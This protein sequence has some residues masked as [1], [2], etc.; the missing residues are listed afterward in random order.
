MQAY[1]DLMRKTM[2]EGADRSA[3]GTGSDTRSLFGAQLRI[4]LKD[5]FPLVTTRRLDFR[6]IVAELLWSIKGD[7]NIA[8]LH[9]YNVTKWDSWADE[10]GYVGPVYGE[11]WRRWECADSRKVDQLRNLIAQIKF[12]PYSRRL[13]LSS[14]NVAYVDQMWVPPSNMI[15]QFY[16]NNNDLGCILSQRTSDLYKRVPETLASYALLTHLMAK[17]CK[18]GVG[19]LIWTGGDVHLYHDDFAKANEQM[20]HT[21]R[22]LSQLKILRDVNFIDQYEVDDI[23]VEGYDPVE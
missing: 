7:T 20:T 6:K 17:E 9:K 1:L 11:Q 8:Y 14:W 5:G 18:L 19:E 3:G 10:N 4:N 12:N 15:A 21:P 22:A 16:V 2:E 23:T 13:I